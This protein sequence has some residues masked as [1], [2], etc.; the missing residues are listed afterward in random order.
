[1]ETDQFEVADSLKNEKIDYQVLETSATGGDISKYTSKTVQNED[2]SFTITNSYVPEKISES[3]KN[4]N[5]GEDTDGLR[6]KINTITLSLWKLETPYA[7]SYTKVEGI[8]DYVVPKD[9]YTKS[10]WKIWSDLPKYANGQLIRY[11]VEETIEYA[12]GET[13]RRRYT[14]TY[15]E[16][17]LE[18]SY[19]TGENA[20]D[21]VVTI[22]IMN[23]YGSEKISVTAKESMG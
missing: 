18:N 1:M 20:K 15:N 23:I 17:P 12:N 8:E 21:S 3:N 10:E 16:Q 22:A 11:R 2:G 9:D 6:K 14:Q 4:M 7:E 19:V 13:R 5:D